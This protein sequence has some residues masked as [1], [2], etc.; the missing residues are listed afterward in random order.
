MPGQLNSEILEAR[1]PGKHT[2][3]RC[4]KFSS[5]MPISPSPGSPPPW[6]GGLQQPGAAAASRR[7]V[8]LPRSGSANPDGRGGDCSLFISVH[9]L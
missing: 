3:V 1:S 6:A 4:I 8:G 2:P 7:L 5:R 9:C